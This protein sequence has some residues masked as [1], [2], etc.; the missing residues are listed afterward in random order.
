MADLS[1]DPRNPFMPFSGRA[2]GQGEREITA[3]RLAGQFYFRD[4]TDR[5]RTAGYA[6]NARLLDVSSHRHAAQDA[7]GHEASLPSNANWI[8]VDFFGMLARLARHYTF[9]R[10]FQVRGRRGAANDVHVQRIF[11]ASEMGKLLGQCAEAGTALG[12]VVLRVMVEDREDEEVA[13]GDEETLPQAIV[14]FVYPG[15]Y[16]PELDPI[17]A[18]RVLSVTM[19]WVLP[20]AS[21]VAA[22]RMLLREIHTPGEVRY[23]LNAWENGELGKAIP[24]GQVFPDLES[25]STG[26]D[27][28]P[29]VHYG[30][31]QRAG[32]HWGS[33]EFDR[34]RRIVF[35]LENRLAQE[36]EVLEKHARPKLI[37]GPGVLDSQ[38]RARLADF[39]VIEIDPNVLEKAVKPE[40]LTWDMQI[41]A[42]QH[43]IEK[44]EEYLF[45]TTE[46]S[47][48]S[49][50]LER[51]GSQV[52]SARALRFKAHRTVNKVEDSRACWEPRLRDVFRIAQKLENAARTEDGVDTYVRGPVQ[53]TWP[54]PIIEDQSQEIQDYVARKGSG[55]VS[56]RRALIDLD[57]LSEREADAEVQEI[58]QDLVDESAAESPPPAELPGV[59]GPGTGEVQ[60]GAPVPAGEET[61]GARV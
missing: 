23:E 25:G 28:I 11:R 47:P 34:I 14:K 1:F 48:A 53:F 38:G 52:E 61:P 39:D 36:D 44:L 26:I 31:Q 60:P 15:F 4:D 41:G 57:Q 56:R 6:D 18:T 3:A 46:T 35:A 22:D 37:V 9:G 30:H 12:D 55:L 17:D 58:L 42:I 8:P 43:E 50:G 2:P 20:A 29:I 40:Y 5:I 19:A 27:E 16:F 7:A 32:E 33:S 24:V 51:D 21:G 13:A 49:F 10:D 59:P 54:D 45:I